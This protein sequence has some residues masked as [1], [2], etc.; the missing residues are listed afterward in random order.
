MPADRRG[1]GQ[2]V[3]VAL[4]GVQVTRKITVQSREEGQAQA[5]QIKRNNDLERLAEQS[6]HFIQL[7]EALGHPPTMKEFQ[8]FEQRSAVLA[9]DVDRAWQMYEA[10]IRSAMDQR[11]HEV[12]DTRP[13]AQE[14]VQSVSRGAP[15]E[16]TVT[17]GKRSWIARLLHR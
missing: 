5:A 7:E 14:P 8:V 10:A 16:G 9:P 12:P 1:F 15:E 2:R 17:P 11:D 13:I 4:G 3:F 6:L